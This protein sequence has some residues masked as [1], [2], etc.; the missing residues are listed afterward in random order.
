[1]NTFFAA[2]RLGGRLPLNS[3]PKNGFG[4]DAEIHWDLGCFVSA[5]RCCLLMR[6]QWQFRITKVADFKVVSDARR[7]G[8]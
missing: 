4:K 8:R 3:L 5:R 6:Q 7:R 1:M 2:L